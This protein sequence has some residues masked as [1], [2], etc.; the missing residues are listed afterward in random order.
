MTDHRSELR[1]ELVAAAARRA[2]ELESRPASTAGRPGE[3]SHRVRRLLLVAASIVLVVGAVTATSSAFG[4]LEFENDGER[5]TAFRIRR[6]ETGAI[7]VEYGRPYEIRAAVSERYGPKIVWQVLGATVQTD[8]P[9]A[10]LPPDA[11]V[12][13][14]MPMDPNTVL[15]A[16]TEG[17]STSPSEL[18]C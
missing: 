1:R 6:S 11:R 12:V 3:G 4:P 8:V 16:V 9:L 5:I 13:L 18:G 17:E 2:E 14:V 10:D 7:S 15:V